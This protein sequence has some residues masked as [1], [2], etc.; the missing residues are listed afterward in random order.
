LL[1]L[2]GKKGSS[3]VMNSLVVTYKDQVRHNPNSPRHDGVPIAKAVPIPGNNNDSS[4]YIVM[5]AEDRA[6]Q[7]PPLPDRERLLALE[8]QVQSLLLRPRRP[9]Q[10]EGPGATGTLL[11]EGVAAANGTDDDAERRLGELEGG[12]L[13]GGVLEGGGL[14]GGG[15]E[16]AR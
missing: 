7:Q 6:E 8:R 2:K 14:E 15:L 10:E 4:N 1:L 12:G 5:V 3:L 11:V 9:R 13:E 16:W